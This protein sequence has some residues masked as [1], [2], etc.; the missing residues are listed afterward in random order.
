MELALNL[1]P[2]DDPASW[3]IEPPNVI[4]CCSDFLAMA[5]GAYS[6]SFAAA[7]VLPMMQAKPAGK[8]IPKVDFGFGLGFT[9]EPPPVRYYS[10]K[11][12]YAKFL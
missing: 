6:L 4:S 10:I 7:K 2:R 8:F 11:L 5:K 12:N 9:H 1:L 3:S